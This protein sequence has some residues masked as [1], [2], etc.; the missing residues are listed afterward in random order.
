MLRLPFAMLVF[1][2]PPAVA[3]AGDWPQWRGPDGSGVAEGSAL[4]EKWSD[5]SGLAW[6][7][8][9]GGQGASSPIV[10]G[11]LVI[12][13][14]QVGRGVVRDGFHPTLVRDG[15]GDPGD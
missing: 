1:L 6:T 11:D 13:T 8:S 9:V 15:D 5:E 10:V 2:L 3:R 4:P 12:V 14:S 7:A